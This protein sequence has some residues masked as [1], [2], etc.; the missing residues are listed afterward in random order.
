MCRCHAWPVKSAGSASPI[1]RSAA[2]RSRTP[3]ARAARD[4]HHRIMAEDK[5]AGYDPWHDPE[6][7]DYHGGA[8]SAAAGE[9]EAIRLPPPGWGEREEEPEQA[10]GPRRHGLKDEGWG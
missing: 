8:A 7:P 3:E 2:V 5:A 4:D 10:P 6:H 9:S 1:A